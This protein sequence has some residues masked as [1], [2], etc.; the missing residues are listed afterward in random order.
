MALPVTM[1]VVTN[2]VA[3][4]PLLF[5]PGRMGKIF[6]V[7]PIVV[8][9]VFLL[10]LVESLFI[11]PNHLTFKKRENKAHSWLQNS[12]LQS[13]VRWQK[14]FNQKFEHWVR[15]YYAAFLQ[16]VIAYRYFV[17]SVFLAVL[18]MILGYVISGRMGMT[19]FPRV[20][21]DYAFASASLKVGAPYQEAEAVMAKLLSKAEEVVAE[22]GASKLAENIFSVISDN[23]VQVQ[24]FLTD[25]E[26][27]SYTHLTLPTIYSV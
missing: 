20:E 6:S 26:T 19:L 11:L 25:P 15:H 21:S 5:V 8:I 10:S 1:S 16:R 18:F 9:S 14:S 27:V 13:M 2:I 24:V 12:W 4:L 3:F 23:T 22:N 17:F 7:I